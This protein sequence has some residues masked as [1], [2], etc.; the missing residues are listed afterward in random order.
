MTVR[1]IFE[2]PIDD[3]KTARLFGKEAGDAEIHIDGAWG[4]TYTGAG[5]CKINLYTV[6]PNEDN[7]IER[8]EVAARLTMTAQTMFALRDYLDS[9]CKTLQEHGVI[10]VKPTKDAAKKEKSKGN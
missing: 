7:N 8:R 4:L 1:Q 6:A 5:T 2:T 9:N 3:G 10:D